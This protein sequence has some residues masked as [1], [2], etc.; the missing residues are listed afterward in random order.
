MK[1]ED[2]TQIDLDMIATTS[3][4][5]NDNKEKYIYG[6]ITKKNKTK[7]RKNPKDWNFLLKPNNCQSLISRGRRERHNWGLDTIYLLLDSKFHP[8][9]PPPNW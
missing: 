3:E 9:A 8:P 2:S 5:V 1:A 4:L 7:Q 6:F